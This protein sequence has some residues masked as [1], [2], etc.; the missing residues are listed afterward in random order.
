[1]PMGTTTH[2]GGVRLKVLLADDHVRVLASAEE[3]L[4]AD[5]RIVAAVTNGRLALEAAKKQ[6]PDLIV[7]DIA[8]PVMDGIDTAKELRRLGSNAKILF[9]TVHEDEGYIAAAR[10]CGDGYVLKSRMHSDLRHAIDEAFAGRFFV[11]RRDLG[12]EK[13]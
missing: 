7:M 6:H 1:M 5:F 11:S 10:T 2:E 9:L 13:R 3:L 4:R 8:M 12:H